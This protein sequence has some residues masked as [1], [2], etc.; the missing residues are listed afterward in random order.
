MWCKHRLL[1][2]S[3]RCGSVYPYISVYI[4][5]VDVYGY[6]LHSLTQHWDNMLHPTIFRL[7]FYL[8]T[9]WKVCDTQKCWPFANSAHLKMMEPAADCPAALSN[10]P[11]PTSASEVLPPRP[12]SHAAAL[13]PL[14]QLP[15]LG[16]GLNNKKARSYLPPPTPN[17]AMGHVHK[18]TLYNSEMKKVATSSLINH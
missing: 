5:N 18:G 4:Y 3:A 13:P 2:N 15:V 8:C 7:Q 11:V 9:V 17:K 6:I 12:N 16:N 10:V 1:I 14:P